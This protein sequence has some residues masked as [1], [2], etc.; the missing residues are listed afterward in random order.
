MQYLLLTEAVLH[1]SVVAI[2]EAGLDKQAEK[3]IGEQVRVFSEQ[4]KLAA[5]M[6]KPLV[7]HCVKAWDELLAVR[8]DF[9]S[10]DIWVI[11]GF[12]GNRQLAEQLIRKGLRLSFG[13][14]FNP[15][16]LRVAW[17]DYLF[18]ETDESDKQIE[19][20]YR[21]AADSLDISIDLLALTLRRNVKE[22]FSV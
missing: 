11:H 12:R 5:E 10:S 13:E 2:G 9:S 20:I 8:K 7:I 18:L 6:G 21:L 16:A 17:P 4:A 19:E 14:K 1:P 15:E 22:V 3:P